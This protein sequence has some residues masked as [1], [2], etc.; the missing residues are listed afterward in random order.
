M[1]GL[2]TEAGKTFN[3]EGGVVKVIAVAGAVPGN[4]LTQTVTAGK[5]WKLLSFSVNLIQGITQTPWPALVVDDGANK[6][7]Q[8]PC[9]TSAQSA[10]VTAQL[11]WA[12]GTAPVGGGASTANVGTLGDELY[13]PAGYRIRT[14]T[15]GIGANTDYDPAKLLVIEYDAV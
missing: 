1:T 8:A 3:T 5:V 15:A 12:I 13:C 14:I 6:L 10:S 9:G 11:T 4:E 2:R 7:F